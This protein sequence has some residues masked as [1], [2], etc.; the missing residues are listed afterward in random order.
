VTKAGSI[1][2]VDD[3]EM[4]HRFVTNSLSIAGF[5]VLA[6]DSGLDGLELFHKDRNRIALVL[7][8]VMMPGMSGPEMIDHILSEVP[9][10]PVLFM[11]GTAAEARLSLHWKQKIVV[12]HKPF[13]S[14]HLVKMVQECLMRAGGAG[15]QI[16]KPQ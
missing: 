12:V 5:P 14:Q 6:A 7:T 8:D 3:D 13:T 10:M 2:V 16:S 1:L 15:D 11:T 9:A 4:V